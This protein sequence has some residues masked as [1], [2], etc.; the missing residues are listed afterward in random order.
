MT[1]QLHHIIRLVDLLNVKLVHPSQKVLSYGGE[2]RKEL[3]AI[4]RGKLS[5][6]EAEETRDRYI[7]RLNDIYDELK[8]AYKP[9][10]VDYEILDKIVMKEFCKG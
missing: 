2:A 3:I 10:D 9:Q 6:K 7:K 8:L 5:L 4:K 1:K